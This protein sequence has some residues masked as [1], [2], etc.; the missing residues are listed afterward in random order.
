MRR[1]AILLAAGGSRRFGVENKLLHLV[2]GE[3]MLQI[4]I[5]T[6][7]ATAIFA[8]I[9]VVCGH[10]QAVIAAIARNS[11][12]ST[13]CADN[14][15]YGIAESIKTGVLAANS[16]DVL[17]FMPA[18]MPYLS[19]RTISAVALA[20]DENHPVACTSSGDYLGVPTAF[21]LKRYRGELLKLT[22]DEGAKHI[23]KKCF[24]PVAIAARAE[25]LVDVD[26]LG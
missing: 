24:S 19:A 6:L 22:G 14:W 10:Q 18:D 15:E 11:G 26:Y 21:L 4:A 12:V 16:T 8:E 9:V 23:L 5:N 20:V 2:H 17:L 13:A 7:R 1:T 3:T 25:E